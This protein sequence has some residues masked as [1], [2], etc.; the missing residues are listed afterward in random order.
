MFKKDNI[1]HMITS[2]LN[3][4]QYQS[5]YDSVLQ[6]VS[7]NVEIPKLVE[8]VIK[9]NEEDLE[10]LR[11]N[12]NNIDHSIYTNPLC[13]I[14]SLALLRERRISIDEFLE[15][16]IKLAI[17]MQFT[18]KQ[19]VSKDDQDIKILSEIKLFSLGEKDIKSKFLYSLSMAYCKK[20]PGKKFDLAEFEKEIDRLPD[21]E[22][23]VVGILMPKMKDSEAR[24]FLKGTLCYFPVLAKGQ[25]YVY[26][27]S[28]AYINLFLKKL[29]PELP[30]KMAP[31]FGSINLSTLYLMHQKGFHPVSLYSPHVKKSNP[32]KIH[33]K[34]I[35][36]LPTSLHDIAAHVYWGNLL[37]SSQFNFLYEYFLPKIGQLFEL[38]ISD[39][40]GGKYRNIFN[41]IDINFVSGLYSAKTP[42]MILYWNL[43]KVLYDFLPADMNNSNEYHDIKKL[44]SE[45]IKDDSYIKEKYNIDIEKLLE[46]ETNADPDPTDNPKIQIILNLI[47]EIKADKIRKL[48]P[49]K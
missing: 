3:H 7:R 5:D 47:K 12:L 8:Q 36:P 13:Q 34:R 16:N 2:S 44:L 1:D 9:E 43:K 27:P 48:W 4:F 14:Y 28:V 17:L 37:P 42:D 33:D 46:N 19:D 22:K 20:F 6:F 21:A 49:N 26:I 11:Q 29:N 15:I 24:S 40:N 41:I 32:K 18:K 38:K 30:I 35:G 45:L 39:I 10:T 31:V 25:N 23:N